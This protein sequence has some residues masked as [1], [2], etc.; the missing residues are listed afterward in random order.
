MAAY[1]L[2]QTIYWALKVTSDGTTPVD[3][4]GGNPTATVTL[5]DGTTAAALVTKV[6]AGHYLAALLSAQLG[7]H[8]VTW[9]GSGANSGGL[10]YADHADVVSGRMI[11]PLADAREA[12]N[13]AAANTANDAELRD[14]IAAATD[15]IEDL[16]GPVLVATRTE[17]V[18][19]RGRACIPLNELP[20]SVTEVKED[21]VSLAASGYCWDE[22]GL[23]WRGSFEGAGVWSSASPRNVI[24]TYT[25][26][27]AVVP[28]NVTLAARELVKHLYSMG[29][30]PTRPAYQ[31]GMGEFSP[32]PS[33]FAV[34][35][36]VIELLAASSGR[37]T[38]GIA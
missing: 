11:I 32:T 33:G 18:S 20:A 21:G 31:V 3:L 27:A 9:A 2:G 26:G 8:V 10:P 25:V 6:S 35:T 16:A 28:T 5:P 36:R 30:L 13:L 7:R 17:T 4:G 22:A 29:Q 38:P 14:Y 37:R 23:L 12:L 1:Q 24:V 15:I 19:G 34:P